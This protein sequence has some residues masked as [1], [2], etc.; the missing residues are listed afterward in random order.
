MVI[1]Q[2]LDRVLQRTCPRSPACKAAMERVEWVIDDGA[3]FYFS[4]MR[5]LVHLDVRR[6]GIT[7]R[8]VAELHWSLPESEIL[9]EPGTDR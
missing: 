1:G 7:S 5:G 4:R 2:A 8:G 6:T 3:C 9:F